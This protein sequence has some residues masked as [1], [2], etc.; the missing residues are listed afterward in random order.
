[1]EV[2]ILNSLKPFKI[3]TW[4][5]KGEKQPILHNFGAK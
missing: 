5:K 4:P 1:M 3:N 2:F